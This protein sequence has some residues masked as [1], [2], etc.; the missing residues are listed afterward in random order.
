MVTHMEL[1]GIGSQIARRIN[2]PAG[3]G[4]TVVTPVDRHVLLSLLSVQLV[5][6][7]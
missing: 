7:A 1:T 6:R 3:R 5:R 2:D 4:L